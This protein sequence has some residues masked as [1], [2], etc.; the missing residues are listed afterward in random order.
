ML[1]PPANLGSDLPEEVGGVFQI[2]RRDLAFGET[3]GS[4]MVFSCG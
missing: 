3:I 1:R 2:G 4:L